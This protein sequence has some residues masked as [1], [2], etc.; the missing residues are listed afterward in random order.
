MNEDTGAWVY[1][2]GMR[3]M[4]SFSLGKNTMVLQT[5]VPA[6]KASAVENIGNSYKNRNIYIP[7]DSQSDSE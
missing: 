2:Y 4:L 3:S 5:E 6:F 7:S 1:E